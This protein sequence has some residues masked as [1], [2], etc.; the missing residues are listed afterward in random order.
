MHHLAHQRGTAGGEGACAGG[1]TGM[2][3]GCVGLRI[4]YFPWNNSGVVLG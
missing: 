1:G 3:V 2:E 4:S